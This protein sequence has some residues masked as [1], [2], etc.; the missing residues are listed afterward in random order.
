MLDWDDMNETDYREKEVP[1]IEITKMEC[2]EAPNFMVRC[3][4]GKNQDEN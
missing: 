2:R 4:A 3:L 1:K